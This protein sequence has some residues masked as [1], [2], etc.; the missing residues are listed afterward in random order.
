MTPLL[1]LAMARN[2]EWS[3]D[4]HVSRQMVLH[5]ATL[6]ASGCFL[7]AVA[8]VAMVLHRV[9]GEWGLVLQLAML[10]GSILVLATV[11]SSG[12]LRRRVKFLIS[13]NFFTH[14]YDYRVE[15]LKFIELVSDPRQAEELQ[16][17]IIR[18]LA[19]FV[20]SPAGVLWSLHPGIGYCPTAGWRLTVPREAK[21]PPDDPFI[22]A[23]RDGIWIQEHSADTT[24]GAW[25]FASSKAWLAV[26]L[27]HRG[28][29]R[30]AEGRVVQHDTVGGSRIFH[31]R[32]L[33]PLLGRRPARDRHLHRL[34]LPIGRPQAS[35]ARRSA[36]ALAPA[37]VAGGEAA[38]GRSL[39]L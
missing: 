19:E 4:I 5:T 14:R 26:P 6:L 38:P 11:L 16:V 35:H 20:D 27:S 24:A 39:S 30:S 33:L 15:W 22:V 2:R 12:S 34:A 21:L 17:R 13:R 1:A 25:S 29:E 8:A 7:L 28:D 36:E 10:F 32:H 3:V 31:R 18:A 23:F 9:G 37:D